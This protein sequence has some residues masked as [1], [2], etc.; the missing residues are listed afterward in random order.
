MD[1][2]RFRSLL[3]LSGEAIL[4]TDIS[5]G[6]FVDMNATAMKWLGYTREELLKMGP[7]DIGAKYEI[8]SP[9][10]WNSS[11]PQIALGRHVRK[12]GSTFP[13][14]VSIS[15][16]EYEGTVYRMAVV[17]D[18]GDRE[19]RSAQE[20]ASLAAAVEQADESIIIT[21]IKGTI[22]YVN[23]SFLETTGYKLDE[24]LGK[25]P[26]LLKSGM[27]DGEFYKAMWS[28]LE[29]GEVWR[30]T[31]INKKKNGALFEEAAT[32]SP[33]RNNAGEVI[34]Y[35]AVKHDITYQR[36]LEK[37]MRESQ[38]LEA[39]GTMA[40]GIAHD[41]NNIL[42]SMLGYINIARDLIDQQSEAKK[43]LDLAIRSGE[44][45]EELIQQIITFSRQGEQELKPVK[46]ESLVKESFK[47][48][49]AMLPSTIEIKLDIQEKGPTVLA[50]PTQIHQILMNL[51]SNANHAMSPSGGLLNIRL[52]DVEVKR[53]LANMHEVPAGRYVCMEVSDTG[54]G[55]PGK[56]LDRIFEP[57]FTTK[58]VDE[59]T[60]L[61]LAVIH[62]V[63]KN[64]KGI[65]EVE[66]V[67]GKGTRFLIYI[68]VVDSEILPPGKPLERDVAGSERILFVDD[69]E[70][71]IKVHK[72]AMERHG[73]KVDITANSSE[74]LNW[75]K[76]NPDG[77]DLVI[78][79]QIMPHMTGDKL[80]S[81]MLRIKPDLPIVLV[82]G[83]DPHMTP[84]KA[85]AMGIR[86]F[87]KKPVLSIKLLETVR[88]IIDDKLDE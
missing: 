46:L 65:I 63:V 28:R 52:T 29:S 35:V 11:E 16:P 84:E 21:D 4:I 75:F 54:C 49:R 62:G 86:A 79:D 20:K 41:F 24:V 13:V 77:W 44:R 15:F 3:D 17:R 85:K 12:D 87:H 69:E 45:A 2:K 53:E 74:A 67:E 9:E 10:E 42:C 58:P 48:L 61:G 47:M 56:N 72:R 32:I 50:D 19:I 81:E 39:I 59:G 22:F 30:G 5:T 57:F 7:P 37:Q 82:T 73:Y 51:S 25:N 36:L 83:Y 76:Q 23:P 60:G 68:P 66:S 80:A 71:L 14:E 43:D 70:L 34:N 18:I 78:T 8:L 33:I 27:H 26:R 6:R 55:I 31:L 64:H 88:Q 40:G 38:K 1:A